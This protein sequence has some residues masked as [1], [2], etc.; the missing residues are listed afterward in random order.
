MT[1][2]RRLVLAFV[3]QVAIALTLV[4]G[5]SYSANV[6]TVY[7]ETDASL[8]SAASA[9]ATGRTVPGGRGDDPDDQPAD[10]PQE[11]PGGPHDQDDLFVSLVQRISPAGG[12][13]AVRGPVPALA[14]TLTDRRLA[15]AGPGLGHFDR[16]RVDGATF[17]TYTLTLGQGRGAI[18]V[19]RDIADNGRVLARIARNTL[20]IGLGVILLAALV[21][22]WIARQ[23]TR[24]LGALSSAAEHGARTADLGAPIETGG[25]DEV[26]SLAE[27]IRTMLGQLAQSRDAQRRLI[28]DAGHELRTPLTSLRTN[29]QVM[30][31][32]D[33]LDD[34]DRARLLADV[35]HELSELTGLVNE[36]VALATDT[37]EGEP[38]QRA[39]LGRLAERAANRVR[40][41][42]GREIRVT[43]D[44]SELEVQPGA[45]ER[46]IGNLLENA[47]KFDPAGT[48]PIE[49]DVAGNTLSVS[50]RG[51]G[52]S[53]DEMESIFDRFHRSA[54]SRGLPG[55]GLGLSIV[56]DI[57]ERHG[58]S[59]TAS[60]RPGGGLTVTITLGAGRPTLSEL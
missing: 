33:H 35:D 30:R 48:A 47:I 10:G 60:L 6:A 51:P 54:T 24:R 40:R 37:H 44:D 42:T 3:A 49:V 26:A 14:P 39:M 2:R 19:G 55:S 16:R 18:I 7:G 32:F 34:A 15:A 57:A 12:V 36:L 38:V 13:T 27:S 43:A 22:W 25:R 53:P 46:A 20:L 45:I 41:R 17:R 56:R 9:L 31:R 1:L 58:G 29:A 5:L 28:E 59:A 11:I 4:G 50:D 21:G 8:I 52:V 23:I